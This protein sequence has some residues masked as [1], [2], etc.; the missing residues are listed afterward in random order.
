MRAFKPNFNIKRAI[1]WFC[2]ELTI[3]G[4]KQKQIIWGPEKKEKE[5][6][7]EEDT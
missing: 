2:W 1:C 6:K 5:E 3:I 7:E 4:N